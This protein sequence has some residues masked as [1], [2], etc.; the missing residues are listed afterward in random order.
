VTLQGKTG[1]A[2]TRKLRKELT[3]ELDKLHGLVSVWRLPV[4]GRHSVD[5][6]LDEVSAKALATQIR[7][8]AAICLDL[9]DQ[10]ESSVPGQEWSHAERKCEPLRKD[11]KQTEDHFRGASGE[12]RRSKGT[13]A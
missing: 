5:R 6:N 7:G 13:N 2:S 4:A 11:L 3:Y 8:Q 10:Y 12:W 9:L 1:V